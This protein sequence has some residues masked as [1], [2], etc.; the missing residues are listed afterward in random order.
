MPGHRALPHSE[1]L[2]LEQSLPWYPWE[3]AGLLRQDSTQRTRQGCGGIRELSP[4]VE[5]PSDNRKQ[6]QQAPGLCWYLQLSPYPG[7]TLQNKLFFKKLWGQR[8]HTCSQVGVDK[9]PSA[10]LGAQQR[11]HTAQQSSLPPAPCLQTR[12]QLTMAIQHKTRALYYYYYC[13]YL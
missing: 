7:C 6:L 10:R 2:L 3:V 12:L 9:P 13:Y 11:H 1:L 4:L 8:A 5:E